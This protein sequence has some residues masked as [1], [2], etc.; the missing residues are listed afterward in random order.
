[1]VV[2]VMVA[3]HHHAGPRPTIDTTPMTHGPPSYDP[4]FPSN[5]SFTSIVRLGLELRLFIKG[6]G[7]SLS[8]AFRL[9]W[10]RDTNRREQQR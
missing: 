10:H 5:Q 7:R 4:L 8:R 2:M 1:M 3:D 9:S 6:I